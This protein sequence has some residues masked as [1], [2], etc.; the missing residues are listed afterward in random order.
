MLIVIFYKKLTV[1]AIFMKKI[2][3]QEI[4]ALNACKDRVNRKLN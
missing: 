1:L 3:E 2:R 4:K